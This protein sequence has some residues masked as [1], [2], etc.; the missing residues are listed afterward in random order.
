[1][2]TRDSFVP[3]VVR[4]RRT[5]PRWRLPRALPVGATAA[6][7]MA[8]AMMSEIN[9]LL[10]SQ[11][12]EPA[13]LTHS[14]VLLA[15]AFL[16]LV[17]FRY[18]WPVSPQPQLTWTLAPQGELDRSRLRR[19]LLP[20]SALV[21][22]D[23]ARTATSAATAAQP[24]SPT[25]ASA[26]AS[27]TFA[28]RIV[29]DVT[30]GLESLTRRSSMHSWVFTPNDSECRD[31]TPLLVFVNP[32][33]GGRQGEATMSQLRALLSP[34]QVIDLKS[35][36]AEEVLQSF[37]TVGRFR[38]LVCGGDGT[39]GW[40]LELLDRASLEYTPPVAILPL[41]TGN[42][43]ARALGWGGRHLGRDLVPLLEEVGSAQVALLDRWQVS[44]EHARPRTQT[45]VSARLQWRHW[46]H[47]RGRGSG[48]FSR[49]C[50]LTR[51]RPHLDNH[52]A[53]DPLPWM[54]P[55]PG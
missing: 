52:L 39:V 55:C 37:R 25:D 16:V 11:G 13:P 30:Q 43:L 51:R 38:V 53:L 19:L 1:M 14:L 31:C 12:R 23:A 9:Q 49:P 28:R 7:L 42:D 15:S 36:D 45:K 8:D 44:I 3:V 47:W 10:H 21:P 50:A 24:P 17:F 48:R 40:V 20:T 33:S 2:T 27:K 26:A 6:G 32:G 46:R 34:Q 54:I 4:P 22:R 41:G 18:L 35:G 29:S 5:R